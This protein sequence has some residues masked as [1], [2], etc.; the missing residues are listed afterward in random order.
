MQDREH[1]QVSKPQFQHPLKLSTTHFH[2][3]LRTIVFHTL[4]ISLVIM[5]KMLHSLVLLI[6]KNLHTK[7]SHVM[8]FIKF[9]SE[10]RGGQN[11]NIIVIYEKEKIGKRAESRTQ[12]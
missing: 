5:R 3:S 8:L 1:L 12:A 4:L 10:Q 7:V 2:R 9:T 6:A 11:I